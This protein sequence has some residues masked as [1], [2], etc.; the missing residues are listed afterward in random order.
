MN[1]FQAYAVSLDD[2]IVAAWDSQVGELANVPGFN[3]IVAQEGAKLLPRFADYYARLRALPRGSSSVADAARDL[4]RR[5]G[6]AA[7]ADA[8][9]RSGGDD[10]RDAEDAGGNQRRRRQM[11]ARGGDRQRQQW[12]RYV[13][14][15]RGGNRRRY[16]RS[17]QR[18]D[19]DH[20]QRRLGQDR[21][22]GD[23][24]EDHNPGKRR[25]NRPQQKS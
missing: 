10:Q 2:T 12:R 15:L 7:R 18:N 16:D 6:A 20:R 14:R 25:E 3:D 13:R 23:Q 8:G 9:S 19:H 5:R 11:L 21:P 17:A 24:Y 4:S 22:P 1:Y